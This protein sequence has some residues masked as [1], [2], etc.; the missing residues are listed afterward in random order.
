MALRFNAITPKKLFPE[1]RKLKSTYEKAQ[2]NQPETSNFENHLS[3]IRTMKKM[4]MPQGKKKKK[5]VKLYIR[6]RK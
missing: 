3:K 5:K 4:A 1:T 6:V 2:K